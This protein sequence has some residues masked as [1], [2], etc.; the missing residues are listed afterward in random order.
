MRRKKH[1]LAKLQWRLC[2]FVDPDDYVDTS[3]AKDAVEAMENSQADMVLFGVNIMKGEKCSGGRDW[4]STL[5]SDQ[6]KRISGCIN[7]WELWGRAY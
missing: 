7:G 6:L 4:D 3:L 1:Q 5:N 2:I